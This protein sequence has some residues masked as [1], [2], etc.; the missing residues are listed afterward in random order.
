MSTIDAVLAPSATATTRTAS[1]DIEEKKTESL[2]V[3]MATARFEPAVHMSKASTG[4]DRESSLVVAVDVPR[5]DPAQA[6]KMDIYLS[7]KTVRLAK[8]CIAGQGSSLLF[9]VWC[10]FATHQS[11]LFLWCRL[12]QGVR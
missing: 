7:D 5:Q 6:F 4:T 11:R 8:K 2:A 10:I 3:S 9:C 12:A 1:N